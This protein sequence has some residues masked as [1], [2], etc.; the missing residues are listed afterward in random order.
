MPYLFIAP[1]HLIVT[2]YLVY[3]EVGWVSFLLAVF[4]LLQLPLNYAS[5]KLFAKTRL[6]VA[7]YPG[8]YGGKERGGGGEDIGG[9]ERRRE[10]RRREGGE[11]R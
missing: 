3:R 2:T 6:V 7:L 1:V 4:V 8:S 10:G 9:E 5:A 11:G